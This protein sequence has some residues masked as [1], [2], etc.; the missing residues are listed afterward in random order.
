MTIKAI[1]Y[2][3]VIKTS[4]CHG[5]IIINNIN[6]AKSKVIFVV[7]MVVRIIKNTNQA[8]TGV[9]NMNSITTLLRAI[10][11]IAE[12]ESKLL[13]IEGKKNRIFYSAH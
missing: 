12:S 7:L 11:S 4:L 5:M 2:S 10:D 13:K 8:R 6:R 9:I 3:R 1:C